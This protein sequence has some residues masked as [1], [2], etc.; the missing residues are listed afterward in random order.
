MALLSI[1][2]RGPPTCVFYALVT[3][4]PITATAQ[5]FAVSPH[6]KQLFYGPANHELGGEVASCG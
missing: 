2:V 1:G 5:Q 4:S 3:V 6:N